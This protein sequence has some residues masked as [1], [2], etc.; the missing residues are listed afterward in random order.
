MQAICN[1]L[2]NR[3]NQQQVCAL[4]FIPKG[5]SSGWSF[6]GQRYYGLVEVQRCYCSYDIRERVGFFL[7]S[8]IPVETLL[9]LDLSSFTDSARLTRCS[10]SLTADR[11]IQ[12][13]H[14]GCFIGASYMNMNKHVQAKQKDPLKRV[15]HQ[16]NVWFS[17]LMHTFFIISTDFIYGGLRIAIKYCKTWITDGQY[18]YKEYFSIFNS[19]FPQSIRLSVTRAQLSFRAGYL[20]HFEQDY[21]T[22][23]SEKTDRR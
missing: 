16:N 3:S 8:G 23:L 15:K 22:I 11:H 5:Y 12:Q 13:I 6:M 19:I 2:L 9:S 18:D 10:M 7:G 17:F 21:H 20:F 4:I 1:Q 14:R